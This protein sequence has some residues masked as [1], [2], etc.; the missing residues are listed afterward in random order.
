MKCN[1]VL[2]PRDPKLKD[3]SSKHQICS[4]INVKK[5]EKGNIKSNIN[6]YSYI[7][8]MYLIYSLR[9]L[10][11]LRGVELS[12]KICQQITLQNHFITVI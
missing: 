6:I 10:C 3:I 11:N 8:G 2:I 9:L 5:K 4:R 12:K 7:A 1:K